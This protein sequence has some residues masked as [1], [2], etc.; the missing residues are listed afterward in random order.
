MGKVKYNS[1]LIMLFILKYRYIKVLQRFYLLLVR[2]FPDRYVKSSGI[3]QNKRLQHLL[4]FT[5]GKKW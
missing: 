5:W 3:K 2:H 4:R 1:L